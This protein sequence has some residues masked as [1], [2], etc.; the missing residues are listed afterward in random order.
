M[1]PPERDSDPL[2]PW[3]TP[4]VLDRSLR[5]TA[6]PVP[7]DREMIEVLPDRMPPAWQHMIRVDL[8]PF[9]CEVAPDRLVLRRSVWTAHADVLRANSR[10]V[11]LARDALLRAGQGPTEEALAQAP[12]LRHWL[13]GRRDAFGPYLLGWQGGSPSQLGLQ[14][15]PLRVFG[16][17]PRRGWACL[18]YG[19]VRLS[20][21]R[22]LDWRPEPRGYKGE[23]AFRLLD[24]KRAAAML[25]WQRAAIERKV[26]AQIA[27]DEPER[28]P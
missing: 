15:G 16:L 11:L 19:W 27:P 26:Q 10:L 24:R 3:L 18:M 25:A 22:S 9:A 4:T 12:H 23:P 21:A 8:L 2:A 14:Y 5:R 1:R 13:M 28:A 20:R 6:R 7:S 17:R